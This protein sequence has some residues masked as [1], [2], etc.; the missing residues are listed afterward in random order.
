[1]RVRATFAMLSASLATPVHAVEVT[2]QN[3]SLSGFGSAVVVGGF[4]TGEKAGSWL[5]SP[6]DGNVRAVQ[7]FWRSQTG[8]S[9]E[10]IHSAIEIFRAGTFPS[11]GALALTIG[12]PVLTDSVLNE[13][14]YLDENQTLPVVVPVV[15]NETFVVSLQF[16]GAIG[17]ADPSVVRDV[18]GNQSGR[19]AILANFGGNFTWFDSALLGVGGDW[20]IRAVVD[21][22]AVA[23]EADVG[24][25][26]ETDPAQYSAGQP[27]TYTIVID[28]A[29]PVASPM[30][31]VVDVFPSAFGAP[32]WTCVG[33]GG[34]T[35]PS[36]GNGNIG[37]SIGLPVGGFV[38]YMV[39]GTVAA[40]TT[41]TLTNSVAAIVGGAV[42]DPLTG[43]NTATTNTV[44]GGAVP[45]FADGFEPESIP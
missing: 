40:G 28:N 8:T 16:D 10:T 12:G 42:T 5:T 43:N 24:V 30:N 29:G 4:A 44:A 11:A 13:Y 27:L 14:R 7:V 38:T 26:M 31:T 21:C 6:C 9:G 1:M 17:A 36:S 23:Q 34:A 2:V 25:E 20:V 35:C 18:D 15:A 33:S 22:A 19:N 32:T 45:I 37:H 41:G 39:N 3:D